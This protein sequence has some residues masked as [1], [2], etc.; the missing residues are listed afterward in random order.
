MSLLR[1]LA[2]LISVLTFAPLAVAQTGETPPTLDGAK[3]VSAAEAK[4]L[5]DAGAQVYD[6][7]RKAAFSE[8]HLPKAKSLSGFQNEQTKQFD[9]AAFGANKQAVIIIHGHGSDG[10]S[11]VQ[12]VKDAVAAG[13]GKVHWLR[14]GFAEWTAAKLPLEQ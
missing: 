10:W 11:A 9:P 4:T 6:A 8:G 13:F 14:G 2:V 12:A 3:T 5:I 1:A 7:R